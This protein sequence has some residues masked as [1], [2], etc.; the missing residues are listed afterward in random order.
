MM[1]L[2]SKT[3]DNIYFGSK[4]RYLFALFKEVI[5]KSISFTFWV[6]IKRALEAIYKGNKLVSQ[7]GVAPIKPF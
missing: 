2:L 7:K 4:D 6:F 3:I 1:L 5:R